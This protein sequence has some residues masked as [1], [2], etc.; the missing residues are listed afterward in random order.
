VKSEVLPEYTKKLLAKFRTEDLP[1]GS[2]LGGGTAIALWIGHRQS[3][4]LD[5][6]APQEFDEKMWQMRWETKLGFVLQ[7]RDWQTL[8]GEIDSVKTALY[9]YKYPMI[10]ATT[11]YNGIEIA[12]LKDLTAMKLDA[13]VSRGTKRDFIDLYFLTKKFGRDEIFEYYGQKYG[14]LEDRQLMIRKALVYF[15]EAEEDEMPRL[16]VPIDWKEVKAYFL[17]TFI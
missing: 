2:Y 17:K 11:V 7:G 8:V 6:F 16:L 12:G 14:H 13:I 9:F 1:P 15:T 10:E 4:D 5:W 3:V